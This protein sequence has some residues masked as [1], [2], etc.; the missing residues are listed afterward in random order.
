MI[1]VGEAW[2]DPFCSWP[3]GFVLGL[4]AIRAANLKNILLHLEV[5]LTGGPWT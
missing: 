5:V 3:G 4:E 1:A 2:L